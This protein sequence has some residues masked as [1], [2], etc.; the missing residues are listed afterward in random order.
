MHVVL[1]TRTFKKRMIK[2]IE[3]I[4]RRAA[5]LV[6]NEY[7][8]TPGTVTKLLNDLK[9]PPLEKR[10]E[11]ARL[12]MMFKVVSSQ[13]AVQI[14]SYI[15]QKKRRGTRQFHPKKLIEVGA[16]INKY[17]HSFLAQSIRDWNSLPN[18]IIEE[19]SDIVGENYKKSSNRSSTQTTRPQSST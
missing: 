5:R 6:K 7:S 2:D 10:M 11:V 1:R 18:H 8:T 9:W 17:K 12:T 19:Q 13:S 15:T 16:K 3:S 14:P 4:K